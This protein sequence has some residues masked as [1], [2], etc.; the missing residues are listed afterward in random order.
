MKDAGIN[1]KKAANLK[2]VRFSPLYISSAPPVHLP[3]ASPIHAPRPLPNDD[4]IPTHPA[5]A[6]APLRPMRLLWLPRLCR[7]RA[8]QSLPTP[9]ML[10]IRTIPVTFDRRSRARGPCRRRF[11]RHPHRAWGPS[12]SSIRR[13][14]RALCSRSFPIRATGGFSLPCPLSSG[15]STLRSHLPASRDP[16]L[17]AFCS[18]RG[19]RTK[20]AIEDHIARD[21][22]QVAPTPRPPALAA[23]ART[24]PFPARAW[25]TDGCVT[26]G[27]SSSA[28]GARHQ[29]GSGKG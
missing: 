18:D 5:H 16:L 29:P 15:C 17:V 14:A 6:T 9:T 21:P 10:M 25:R 28:G 2:Q 27:K 23:P 11:H 13:P 19:R 22:E 24:A 1:G 20:S 26:A 7:L 4:P 3:T 8:L 12:A